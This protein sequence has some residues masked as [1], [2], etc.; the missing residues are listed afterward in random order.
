MKLN[1][2]ALLPHLVAVALFVVI[3][4]VYFYPALQGYT[5]KMRDIES[6]KGMSKELNDFRNETGRRSTL[7]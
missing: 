6:H 4:M 7:D 5:L 2:K 1:F 3:S